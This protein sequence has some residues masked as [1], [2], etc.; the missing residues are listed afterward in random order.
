MQET[1]AGEA[2]KPERCSMGEER[3]SR[4]RERAV[5]EKVDGCLRGCTESGGVRSA[6]GSG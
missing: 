1:E 2:R 5:K 6:C 4:G 3:G